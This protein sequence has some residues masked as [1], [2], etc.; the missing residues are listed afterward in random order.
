MKRFWEQLKPNE[1][2]VVVIVVIAFFLVMNW[3]FVWPHFSDFG[4][5]TARIHGAE[6]KLK[7]SSRRDCPQ[8]RN[9]A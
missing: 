4:R 1:R 6:E 2:R 5:D 7:T 8:G 9:H 3:W